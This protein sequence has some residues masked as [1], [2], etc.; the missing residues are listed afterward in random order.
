MCI[1]DRR[2]CVAR[3]EG[4]ERAPAHVGRGHFAGRVGERFAGYVVAVKPFG[5]VVQLAGV[6]V[7]GTIQTDTLPEGPYRVDKMGLVSA[8]RRFTVGDA[9][10]VEVASASEEL[11]RIE[12]TLLP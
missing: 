11:A 10:Q 7:S 9:L 1:R 3:H 2:S 5:L 12:L 4:R 8:K 6:G